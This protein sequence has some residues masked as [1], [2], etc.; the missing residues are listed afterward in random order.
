MVGER[1]LRSR[2]KEVK[3][4]GSSPRRLRQRGEQVRYDIFYCKQQKDEENNYDDDHDE[5]A[6]EKRYNQISPEKVL[7]R[8]TCGTKKGILNKRRLRRGELC[9]MYNG[10]WIS[11]TDFE[12]YGG[13]SSAKKWKYSIHHDNKPLEFFF[14]TGHLCTGGFKFKKTHLTKDKVLALSEDSEAHSS[15]DNEENRWDSSAVTDEEDVMEDGR[16]AEKSEVK[17]SERNEIDHEDST[18]S[19][20]ISKDQP[21]LKEMHPS[22]SAKIPPTSAYPVVAIERLPGCWNVGESQVLSDEESDSVIEVTEDSSSEEDDSDVTRV[23]TPSLPFERVAVGE[24]K[25][26]LAQSGEMLEQTSAK[27][28][29]DKGIREDLKSS[30]KLN[31]YVTT[32]CSAESLREHNHHAPKLQDGLPNSVA[33]QSSRISHCTHSASPRTSTP[34]NVDKMDL[35]QLKREKLKRQLKVLQLQEEYYTL[36]LNKLKGK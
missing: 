9:I 10:K 14:R 22:I 31:P 35:D 34:A 26:R 25:E 32:D 5:E 17:E 8:V 29:V 15:A 27:S 11:P 20:E 23:S 30:T 4:E 7:W 13:R 3:L 36:K 18:A 19:V 6:E 1:S 16:E 33:S 28:T 12:A 24:N 2:E 21:A